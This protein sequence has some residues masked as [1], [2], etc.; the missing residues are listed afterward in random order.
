MKTTID[1]AA[2]MTNIGKYQ[3]VREI[4]RGGMGK[5]YHAIDSVMKRSVA[6]KVTRWSDLDDP[7][8]REEQKKRLLRDARNAGQLKHPH[9]VTVYGFEEEGD[10]VFIVMELIEGT[11]LAQVLRGG[12]KPPLETTVRY[13][14]EAASALDYAHKNQI[15]HRDFKPQNVLINTEDTVRIA[16][17]GISKSLRSTTVEPTDTHDGVVVGTL[18]Y[19]SPERIFGGDI[20][21]RA[22]LFSLGVVAFQM[23]T[24][25]FPFPGHEA[26]SVIFKIAYEEPMAPELLNPSISPAAGAVLRKALAKKRED[27]YASCTEFA[28]ALGEALGVQSR[29]PLNPLAPL[30]RQARRVAAQAARMPVSAKAALAVLLVIPLPSWWWYKNLGRAA[31]RMVSAET[32]LTVPQPGEVE[33][34]SWSP[35][36]TLAVAVGENGVRIFRAPEWRTASVLAAGPTLATSFSHRG[37]ILATAGKPSIRLW[38]PAEDR[39][40][41]LL[42]GHTDW[43]TCLSFAPGDNLLASGSDDQTV[44]VWDLSNGAE[45]KDLLTRVDVTSIAFSPDGITLAMGA[46]D[47]SILLKGTEDRS[48]RVLRGHDRAVTSVAFSPDGGILVSGSED[49]AV[50]LWKMGSEQ[51]VS[52]LNATSP[53]RSVAFSPGGMQLVSGSDD[54]VVRLWAVPPGR[55]QR[56]LPGHRGAVTGLALSVGRPALL[57][58]SGS[59]DKSLHLWRLRGD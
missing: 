37:R 57:M 30:V 5:V 3:V 43:V 51:A 25:E 31:V 18:Y 26:P 2:A 42:E 33:G 53:V 10:L 44:R 9:I 59:R 14:H 4:G 7:R 45:M 34:L 40:V 47:G 39:Q 27:R 22:D 55:L 15:V 35:D 56:S 6:L 49:G 8:E 19:M 48:S 50:A 23:L 58:A 1:R 13:L 52:V 32:F 12:K 38:N 41:G 16:D 11:S 54:G 24:G 29:A 28:D 20:D 46:R 36:G 21:G 17:F